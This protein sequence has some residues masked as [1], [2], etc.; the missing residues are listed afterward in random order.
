LRTRQGLAN[1]SEQQQPSYR[2]KAIEEAAHVGTP[3]N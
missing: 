2:R 1:Q 3:P